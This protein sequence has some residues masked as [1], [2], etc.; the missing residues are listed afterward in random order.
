MLWSCEAVTRVL[1]G[2]NRV[3]AAHLQETLNFLHVCHPI[4]FCI[5]RADGGYDIRMLFKQQSENAV[6]ARGNQDIYARE[7]QIVQG[8]LAII[9]GQMTASKTR[10][11]KAMT[12]A[13]CTSFGSRSLLSSANTPCSLL[14][15]VFVFS[16]SAVLRPIP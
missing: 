11:A 7:L 6:M 8:I 15:L 14:F 4:Q 2:L 10:I 5:C 1:K 9:S 3:E 16:V 12:A 13:A